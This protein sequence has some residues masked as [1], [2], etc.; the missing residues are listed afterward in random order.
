MSKPPEYEPRRL[1]D[2]ENENGYLESDKDYV[3]N[4]IELA[5]WLLERWERREDINL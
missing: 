2:D 4:N 3:I 1:F 5:V